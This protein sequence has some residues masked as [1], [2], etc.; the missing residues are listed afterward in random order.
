MSTSAAQYLSVMYLHMKRTCTQRICNALHW[1]A[2]TDKRF[3]ACLA[4]IWCADDA[5]AKLCVFTQNKSFSCTSS[6]EQS[7]PLWLFG[8]A[9]CLYYFILSVF[10]LNTVMAIA[11]C[12]L[13]CL[14]LHA[15][16][17][18]FFDSSICRVYTV[19]LA[20]HIHPMSLMMD[21]SSCLRHV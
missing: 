19:R 16:C 13:K 20:E 4:Q 11:Y 8:V 5:A 7:V 6:G 14:S 3:H 12:F 21:L 18:L 9:Y 2:G 17:G 15:G 10:E 1:T